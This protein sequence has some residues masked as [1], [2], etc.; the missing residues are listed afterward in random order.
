MERLKAMKNMLMSCVEGQMTHLEEVDAKELGEVVDMIKDLEEA[1]Y[2]C[3][4]VEA[5]NNPEAHGFEQS[6]QYYQEPRIY[7]NNPWSRAENGGGRSYYGGGNV[8]HSSGQGGGSSS[9]SNNGSSSMPY[10]EREYPYEFRDLRE[11]RSPRSR[12]MYMEAKETHQD[13]TSQM[14]ELEKYM[15]E[16]AQDLVEMVD[17]ASPEEKQYLSKKISALSNKL[18]Q[19]ND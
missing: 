17:G 9:G 1:I 2:Y 16:L 12:R 13:K 7:Y 11:G 5:M 6:Q 10:T 4:I 19:L 3:T 14:R 18:S 15:Q 8:P